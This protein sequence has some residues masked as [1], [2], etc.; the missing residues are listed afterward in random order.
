VLP[1]IDQKS[2]LP[3]HASLKDFLG[4]V[5]RSNVHFLDPKI[6]HV[7]ILVNC[8]QLIGLAHENQGSQPLE[9]ACQQWCY[10][11]YWALSRQATIGGDV[12]ILMVKMMRQWLRTWMYGLDR[13]GL[14]SVCQDCKS[15][16]EQIV[17]SCI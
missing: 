11:M 7:T 8:L 1:D 4:N 13:E 17:V 6:Y 3:Y 5:N 16:L 2:I 14:R 12:Q 15:V 9:Y 10:H